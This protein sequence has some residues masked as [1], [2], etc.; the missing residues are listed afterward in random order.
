MREENR[1]TKKIKVIVVD[2]HELIRAAIK[3]GLEGDEQIAVVGEGCNGDDLRRLVATLTPDVLITDLQMPDSSQ[4]NEPFQPITELNK[5]LV[6]NP[7]LKIIVISQEVD[8]LL[9]KTLTE[10]GIK[11]YLSKSDQFG[12]ALNN[13]VKMCATTG[14]GYFSRNIQEILIK[15]KVSREIQLSDKEHEVLRTIAKYPHL[16]RKEIAKKLFIAESTLK[17]H[18]NNLFKNLN[19]PNME[20]CLLKAIQIDLI[21][22]NELWDGEN[23]T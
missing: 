9:I 20:S 19:V 6:Q 11:G 21:S 7:D 1:S 5:A 18:V 17:K 10:I 12:S 4:G 13:I 2:D 14:G 23:T 22:Q 8:V 3:N 16:T 15:S